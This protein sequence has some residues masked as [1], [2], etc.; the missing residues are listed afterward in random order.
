MK[1]QIL[2]LILF[3]AFFVAWQKWRGI[4]LPLHK[5][6]QLWCIIWGLIGITGLALGLIRYHG[7][8]A[9]RAA[10]EP[11]DPDIVVSTVGLLTHVST[12]LMV[13]G[14]IGLIVSS[15][16]FFLSRRQRSDY[17]A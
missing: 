5:G 17:A 12:V 7:A 13:I 15:T 11:A 14:I 6:S 2:G 8:A 4:Q 1:I 16:Y 10:L 9:H 3:I